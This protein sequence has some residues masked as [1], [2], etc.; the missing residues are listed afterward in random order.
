MGKSIALDFD[1]VIHD[2]ALGYTGHVPEGGPVPGALEFVQELLEAGWTVYIHTCR[3]L[4][5]QEGWK[6]R[7]ERVGAVTEWLEW[8]G[9]PGG[10]IVTADKPHALLY[11]DDRAHRFTGC[12]EEVRRALHL[13]TWQEGERHG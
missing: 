8:H 1:G 13:P 5:E 6:P 3:A 10:L 4:P 2:Y 12:W 7:V 11:V 9:F